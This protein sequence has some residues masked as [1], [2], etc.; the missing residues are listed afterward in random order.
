M[1]SNK[2]IRRGLVIAVAVSVATIVVIFLV[3]MDRDT[4]SAIAKISPVFFL[5][6]L[7]LVTARQLVTCIRMRLLIQAMGSELSFGKTTKAVLGAGF[8]G[9]VTPYHAGGIPAEIYFLH[10][11]GLTGGEATA[12]VTTGASLSILLFTLLMPVAL[13]LSASRMHV[14]F[15]VRTLLVAAS[16]AALFFFLAFIYSMKEPEKLARV[17]EARAPG[18]LRKKPRFHRGVESFRRGMGDF[19]AS[20]R[21]IMGAK[22]SLL[23]WI[24]LLTLAFWACGFFVSPVILW[25]VG[26]PELFWKAFL[27]QLVVSSLMP[28]VP[29]PGESGMAEA[30]FATVFAVFVPKNL[31]GF[32]TLSWRFFMFYLEV[33]VL[34]IVFVVAVR[35]AGRAK[36]ARKES[37]VPDE[38]PAVGP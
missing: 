3:T 33:L 10:S 34:G 25:G 28:F 8:A 35:D 22:K 7:V 17:I 19:S 21:A 14:S 16:I 31:V 26:Y 9:S 13:V 11:Y 27:A 12:V 24:V 30:A 6:A 36:D 32:M 18:F 15:G 2:N 38:S 4:W 1:R 20:L 5:L 23:F 29:V 37:P